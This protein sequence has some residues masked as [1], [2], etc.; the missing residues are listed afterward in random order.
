VGSSVWFTSA[1]NSIKSFIGDKDLKF[2]DVTPDWLLKYEN[3]LRNGGKKDTTIS[4]NQR[5]LRVIINEGKTAGVIKESQYP[6]VVR[7]NGKYQIPDAKGQ[8]GH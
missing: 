2:A 4:I 8:S 5:A 3:H 7:Q 6:Y 1:K